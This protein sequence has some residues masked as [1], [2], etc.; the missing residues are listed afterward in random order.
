MDAQMPT[1]TM[2]TA[3]IAVFTGPRAVAFI[4][5]PVD[6]L[7]PNDA[8]VQTLFS[9]ISHGTEMNV[10]RGKAPQWSKRYDPVLRLFV[11]VS[12][13]AAIPPSRGYWKPSDTHWDY[14]L[15]YGYQNVGRVVEVG[16][17]VTTVKPDDLVFAYEPHQ[18]MC[19][20]PAASL[21]RLPN[22][23]NPAQGVV[24]SNINTAYNG[25]LD[26]DIRLDDVVVI[27]GQGLIG[28]LVTQFVRRSA[29]QK[30]IVVDP[31][32][33]RREIALRL[34]AT[35][36]LDPKAGDVA[37]QIREQTDGRGADVTIDVTGS[38]AALQE[39]IR[40]AA[41]N[42]TVIALSWYG[43]TAEALNLSEEFHHNRI[44]IK[45]SQVAAV[46]PDLS[47]THSVSRRMAHVLEAFDTLEIDSLLTHRLPFT[48]A[49]MAYDLVDNHSSEVIQVYLEYTK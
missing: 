43:G 1:T 29:A 12:P 38:Y 47:A 2:N 49:A 10:Y 4:D 7:G 9:G 28:L 45:C 8:R 6:V 19:V 5:R 11:P 33:S 27:F 21:I 25:V 40:A 31:I 16:T 14:P 20:A 37:L 48:D 42:T 22:L 41:P 39:A 23:R 34:G 15:A 18:T 13:E 26:A 24:Y 46:D 32:A 44:T 36:A 35:A 3:K 30:V 17:S